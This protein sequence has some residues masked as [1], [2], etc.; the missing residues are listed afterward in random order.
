MDQLAKVIRSIPDHEDPTEKISVRHLNFYY[1]DGNHALKDV[2]VPIYANRVTAFIG[3]SGCGKSTLLRV[4]NR[5]YALYPG[6]RVEGDVLLD[7]VNIL[8]KD[9]DPTVLRTRIGMVFQ[10][11]TPFPMSVYD[12]IAFGIGLNR[13]LSK[14]QMDE[15]VELALRRV[16]LWDEV[17]DHLARTGLELSGGQ[18]QRLCIARTIATRPEVL[19]LDEPC[20]SID[21]ISSAKI[22]QTID[23][24]K[25]D[26]TIVIVTHNLQQAAR[27]SDYAGFMYLGEMSEFG[28]V[29]RIFVTPGDPRTQR[30][31]TG[32]FG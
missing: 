15:E 14:Q 10:K 17:K 16:A 8:S 32:R 30:F 22:E 11:P 19:L 13:K 7:G 24:L 6:Q 5:I 12:N 21:P 25:H 20:A 3:P 26:H 2:S 29:R 28:P 27:V 1:Q 18:Q 9:E 4:F 31:I 23:E